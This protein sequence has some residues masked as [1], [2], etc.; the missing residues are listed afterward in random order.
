MLQRLSVSVCI[1]VVLL[2]GLLFAQQT[3]S[4]KALSR[5]RIQRRIQHRLPAKTVC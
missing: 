1:G 2:C 4:A 3:P 5:G